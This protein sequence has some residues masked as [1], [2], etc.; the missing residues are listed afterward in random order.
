MHRRTAFTLIE[1]LVVIAIIAVLIG[2]LVPAVQKVREAAAKTKCQNQLKQLALSAHAYHD[3]NDSFPAGVAMP[4]PDGRGTSAFVELLPFIEQ[5]NVYQRWNF[6]NPGSNFGGDTTTAAIPLPNFVCPSSGVDTPVRFGSL[7]LGST[8]YGVNGGFKTFPPS[9][10][11]NDGMFG[12]STATSR[13]QIRILDVTDGTSSTI[14]LGER[15]IGDPGMDSYQIAPISPVP[16]PSVQA[17]TAYVGWAQPP[18]ANAGA[19]LLLSGSVPIGSGFPDQYVP[20]P[21]N[22]PPPTPPP[23]I[24]WGTLGPKIW[25]RLSAYGS[26]HLGGAN[27]AFADG[28]IRFLRNSTPFATVASLSTRAGGEVVGVE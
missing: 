23:P 22:P 21:T 2:L 12:Y 7:T 26:R 16:T 10:A 17:S 1:L 25:D 13:N 4:G 5:N 28:S 15:I 19:G 11:T 14:L 18:G 9:R 8:T 3:S 6:A 24:P 27:F 20:P